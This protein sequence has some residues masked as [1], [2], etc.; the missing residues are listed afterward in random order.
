MQENI[1]NRLSDFNQRRA[2]LDS[3]FEVLKKDA[4]EQCRELVE[5]FGLTAE[6]LDLETSSMPVR[7]P[8][9]RTCRPKYRNPADEHMT[10]SGRGMAPTW[11]KQAIDAGIT[12]EEMLI[13]A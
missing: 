5:A 1:R 10:W 2:E 9:R 13:P 8:L 11:F 4:I 3:E 7:L 6:D 12:K